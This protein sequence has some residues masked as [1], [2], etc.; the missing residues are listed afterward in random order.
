MPSGHGLEAAPIRKR[1]LIVVAYAAV[2]LAGWWALWG[3]RSSEPQRLLSRAPARTRTDAAISSSGARSYALRE[4]TLVH[5]VAGYVA[6]E[7]VD[8]KR[9]DAKKMFVGA[10]RGVERS[11]PEV[12]VVEHPRVGEDDVP[13][14]VEVRVLDRIKRF[15][16]ASIDGTYKL[17]WR[18]KDVAAF[19][20]DSLPPD[21]SRQD[22]EYAMVSGMLEPLDP[23]TVVLPPDVYREMEIG[24]TGRFGG[25]GIVIT[26]RDGELTIVSVMPGTP[27]ARAGL[28]S[29]DRIVQIDDE[30]TINMSLDEAV[31]HMR[32]EPGS[33]VTIHVMRRGWDEPHAFEIVREE[34]RVESVQSKDLGHGVGYVRIKS[35]Q[36]ET[37]REVKRAI[38]ALR[39]TGS[40]RKGLVLDLR[41]NPGGLLDEA[42]AVADL[43]LR[44]GTIV[45]TVGA[46]S[47]IRE[48]RG[49][50][51][52]TAVYAGLPLVLL[53][54]SGSASA[55]EIV[56]G[57]LKFNDRALVVGEQTFGKG[58]VQVLYPLRDSANQKAALKLTIAQYLLPGDRSLQGVGIVPD[59]L[60][61]PVIL[62]RKHVDLYVTP[63]DLAGE[64]DLKHH[65]VN[66]RAKAG[67]AAEILRYFDPKLQPSDDD[68]NEDDDVFEEYGAIEEDWLMDFAAGLLR[69]APKPRRKEELHRAGAYLERVKA[70][71]EAKIRERLASFG[72]DWTPAPSRPN[73][74]QLA[75]NLDVTWRLEGKS[76]V[77]AGGDLTLV[78]TVTNRGSRPVYRVRGTTNSD[79]PLFDN[80]ELVIGKVDPGQTRSWPLRVRVPLWA[81]ART[82]VVSLDVFADETALEG[83]RRETV[84]AVRE[85]PLPRL[86]WSWAVRDEGKLT[87]GVL[88]PG[89]KV[90][91]DVWVRNVGPGAARE[92]RLRLK[93]ESGA[94]IFLERGKSTLK[95][96]L[97]PGAWA[98]ARFVFRV[99]E[100]PDDGWAAFNLFALDSKLREFLQFPL[101]LRAI[102]PPALAVREAPPRVVAPE[103]Q[104]LRAAARADAPVV[105][106]VRRAGALAADAVAGTW[107]RVHGTQPVEWQ[108]WM[109]LE[110]GAPP[111]ASPDAGAAVVEI[112]PVVVAPRVEVERPEA[113][114]DSEATA[115]HLAVDAD[116]AGR[117]AT[118]RDAW[119]FVENDKVAYR[120]VR[121]G[122]DGT[123]HLRLETDVPL[124]KGLNHIEID[125]RN[126]KD[127]VVRREILVYRR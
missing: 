33:K 22:V 18:V 46:G 94:A 43:F 10:L 23:H 124:D 72:V 93:N 105:A 36:E 76:P 19:L 55:A 8:P 96:G 68:E 77:E 106:R 81:P 127:S 34:I 64:K 114:V 44:D 86:A 66:E 70:R 79:D 58:S 56:T 54:N 99:R 52:S 92:L 89:E 109:Q 29:R 13:R 83:L 21:V 38:A 113:L 116:F 30:S 26:L 39:K 115:A 35:F 41:D 32:G 123:A 5:R 78:M 42:V 122:T 28:R 16:V 50:T 112:R 101:R 24:T 37:S 87:D 117:G 121:V 69:A 104:L 7:Y 98:T 119:V 15:D 62:T 4:L 102:A 84:V 3:H 2:L 80:R 65:L 91:L 47:G 45:V 51:R 59:V 111:P 49:A 67:M 90:R 88:S 60:T 108:A 75:R 110:E 48:E 1:L 97:A 107:V 25:L 11:V 71:Q 9:A 53:V 100:L 73:A 57:A 63:K 95:D 6:S 82:S 74:K 126:D 120:R 103:G 20:D 118:W 85:Q 14:T 61:Y 27:A 17:L 12:L 125:V 40:A 31:Q